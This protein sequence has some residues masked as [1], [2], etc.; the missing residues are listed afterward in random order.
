MA[1]DNSTNAYGRFNGDN[2][3][4]SCSAVLEDWIQLFD[5][6]PFYDQKALDPLYKKYIKTCG[7]FNGEYNMQTWRFLNENRIECDRIIKQIHISDD[8]GKICYGSKFE[9]KNLH[10][11]FAT[12]D[13]DINKKFKTFYMF[14]LK[15]AEKIEKLK[16]IND[17]LDKREKNN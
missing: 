6:S 7:V 5:V 3:W 1:Y 4:V 2:V 17:V 16:I 11:H 8:D 10:F 14:I 15:N 9:V 12:E 13:F